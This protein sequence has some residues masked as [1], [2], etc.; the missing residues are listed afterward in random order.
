MGNPHKSRAGIQETAA[1]IFFSI[2]LADDEPLQRLSSLPHFVLQAP[3]PQY[4]HH[5]G[6]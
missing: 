2:L 4:P 5:G 1:A 3:L 6:T